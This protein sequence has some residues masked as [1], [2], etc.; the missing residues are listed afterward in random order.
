M[1]DF[2]GRRGGGG[3]RQYTGRAVVASDGAMAA[4]GGTAVCAGVDI[5]DCG[6]DISKTVATNSVRGRR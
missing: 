4:G 3:S 6:V 1:V 2:R 5:V